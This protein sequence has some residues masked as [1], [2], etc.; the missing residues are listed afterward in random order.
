MNKRSIFKKS[1][2]KDSKVYDGTCTVLDSADLMASIPQ[3]ASPNKQIIAQK[4]IEWRWRFFEIGS[5]KLIEMSHADINNNRTFID[6]IGEPI[7]YDLDPE[8]DKFV[9]KTLYA[10]VNQ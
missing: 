1:D 10:Y 9:V 8:W 3:N 6:Q 4:Q 5:R 2:A 7:S